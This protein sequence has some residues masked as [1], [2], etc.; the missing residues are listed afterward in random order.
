VFLQQL[1]L[2][3]QAVTR[4][5]EALIVIPTYRRESNACLDRRVPPRPCQWRLRG[6]D[7]PLDAIRAARAGLAAETLTLP[8]AGNSADP[9]AQS[10][11]TPPNPVASTV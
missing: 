1:R 9:A 11:T 3:S 2:A 6:K 10:A 8:R 5:H 7:D 4:Q